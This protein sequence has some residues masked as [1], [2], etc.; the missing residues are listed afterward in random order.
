VC[1]IKG[2]YIRLNYIL[3]KSGFDFQEGKYIFLLSGVHTCT[4]PHP[5]CYP[6]NTRGFFPGVRLPGHSP[7][8]SA[9]IK[10]T[11]I[12]LHSPIQFSWHSAEL[13]KHRDNFTFSCAIASSPP[14][15]AHIGLCFSWLNP[16][17]IIFRGHKYMFQ[18][19]LEI[20]VINY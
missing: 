4:R 20:N 9:V 13:I 19:Y 3:Y 1:V 16:F 2:I 12:D 17:L 10:S 14:P 15:P 18:A 6:L 8:S 11:W 7:P 5:A